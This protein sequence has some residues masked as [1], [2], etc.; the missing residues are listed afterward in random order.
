MKQIGEYLITHS[1]I[2]KGAFASIHKGKHIYSNAT[3]A[4]KEIILTNQNLKTYI[5]KQHK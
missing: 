3:V 4:I 1:N 5:S 2:A